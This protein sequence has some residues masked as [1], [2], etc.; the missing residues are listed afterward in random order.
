MAGDGT[1]LPTQAE[2]VKKTEKITKKIQ[3]LLQSAQEGKYESFAPCSLKIHAAVVDMAS[4]FPKRL[5][6]A[7]SIRC[8]LLLL[9]SSATRLTEECQ[10]CP[11]KHHSSFDPQLKTQQVIQSAFDIAK[12]AKQLVTL[13]Q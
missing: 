11:E 5:P 12:A 3:E 2:V 13:F 1:G 4:L 6:K 9:T 7:E 10:E 8:A